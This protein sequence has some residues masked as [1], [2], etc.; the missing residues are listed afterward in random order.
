[1]ALTELPLP[2]QP[3]AVSAT[4]TAGALNGYANGFSLS[5]AAT[6]WDRASNEQRADW[7]SWAVEHSPLG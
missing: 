3:A 4:G 7:A 6:R 5:G 1:M 2:G